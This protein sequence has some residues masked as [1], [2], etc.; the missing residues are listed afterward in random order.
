MSS[1]W[2][3]APNLWILGK[4]RKKHQS[5]KGW[6]G[7]KL[8]L[9]VINWDERTT[10]S[11][12][13]MCPCQQSSHCHHKWRGGSRYLE[14]WPSNRTASP[15]PAVK[16][17]QL[18]WARGADRDGR[19]WSP[20]AGGGGLCTFRVRRSWLRGRWEMQERGGLRRGEAQKDRKM[21][22]WV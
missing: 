8:I 12:S 11:P 3:T 22:W 2:P 1:I 13:S 21:R 10:S 4:K 7:K 18:G 5:A 9:R 17:H 6:C 15:I 20:S 19:P 14:S 16:F